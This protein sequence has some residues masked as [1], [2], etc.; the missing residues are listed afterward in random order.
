[1]EKRTFL[2]LAGL[3]SAGLLVSP[4]M[5]CGT[6]KDEDQPAEATQPGEYKMFVQEP[7]GY[8]WD[9]LEPDLDAA[10]MELH[11]SR[12]HATYVEQLNIALRE[13]PAKYGMDLQT[14]LHSLTPEETALRNHGGGHFNHTMFWRVLTPGGSTAPQGAFLQELEKTFGSFASFQ[15]LFADAGSKRFGSGWAWLIRNPAGKLE[16]T[17]TPNQDNPVMEGI[18]EQPGTP[19]LCMDVWE[20]AYYLNYQNR[21]T[22]YIQAFFRR[23]NWDQV[24]DFYE[25]SRTQPSA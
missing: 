9:A 4:W 22:D 11:Y 14:L 10:T 3:G 15:Q 7:L 13:V 18:A 1:M 20:H 12:H 16:V 23:I 24:N 17:S 8:S 6:K 19:I 5:A 25:A 2:K 21:R